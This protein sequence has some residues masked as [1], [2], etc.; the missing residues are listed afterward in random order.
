[1]TRPSAL[2]ALVTTGPVGF[3][4]WPAADADRARRAGRAAAQDV[5]RVAATAGRRGLARL[6]FFLL[7]IVGLWLIGLG[8]WTPAKAWYAQALLD[9]AFVDS[10]TLGHPVRAWSWAEATPVA[11]IRV[12]RLGVEEIVLSGD[13]SEAPAF[14]P[15][16]LPGGTLGAE[17]NA[18][19]AGHR[20]GHFAF[21]A[22]LR[23]GDL[24]EVE[25]V[26][27][28]TLRFR[29]GAGQ[30]V[31]DGPG[32]DARAPRPSIALTTAWPAGGSDRGALRYVVRAE[33]ESAG[34]TA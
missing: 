20:D 18:V 28:P 4:W 7:A 22:D 33:A 19:F 30:V 21:L 15:T 34:P 14:G 9:R 26:T 25:P 6:P 12:P 2:P 23:P 11:R 32:I 13:W 31:R 1:M 8:A 5:G 29:A 3:H 24:I 27:G 17:G 16:L 10:R